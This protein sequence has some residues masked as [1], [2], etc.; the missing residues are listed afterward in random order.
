MLQSYSNEVQETSKAQLRKSMVN[1][2]VNSGKL[3][4]GF[5]QHKDGV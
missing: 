2:D 4:L 5:R 3:G 1:Y